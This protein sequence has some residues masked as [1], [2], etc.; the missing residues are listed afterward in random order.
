MLWVKT[1][2]PCHHEHANGDEQRLSSVLLRLVT[3]P[4]GSELIGP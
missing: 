4:N 3:A 2:S 1:N